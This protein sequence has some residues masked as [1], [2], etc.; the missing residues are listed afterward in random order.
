M[1]LGIRVVITI[2]VVVIIIAVLI[3]LTFVI[4]VD[5]PRFSQY[6]PSFCLQILSLPGS[7]LERS[8]HAPDGIYIVFIATGEGGAALLEVGSLSGKELG[9]EVTGGFV[10]GISALAG[11]SV[12][13]LG[14]CGQKT[15]VVGWTAES[16]FASSLYRG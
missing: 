14:V 10:V 1:Q 9:G 3:L 2:I 12:L 4:S 6:P 16:F 8:L 5:V 7:Q 13:E 15:L 11:F